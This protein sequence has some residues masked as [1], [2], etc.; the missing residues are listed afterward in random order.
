MTDKELINKAIEALKYSYSP[1]SEFSVGVALLCMNGN[2]YTGCNIENAS[3]SATLCAERTAFAK[4]L[5][6]GVKDFLTIA[7]V[8]GKKGKITDFCLPCGVCRQVM[9][10]FCSDNFKIIIFNG[11]E[12]KTYTLNS[13]LPQSFGREDLC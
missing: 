12:T 8:G 7:I 11:K 3:F 5:S 10:E 4:A 1:Y 2:V 6:E 13:L 9:A